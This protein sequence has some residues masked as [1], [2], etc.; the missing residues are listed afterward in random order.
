M[1]FYEEIVELYLTAVEGCAVIPQVPILESTTG[2]P[3]EAYPD[4]L[5]IDFSK[6]EISIVEVTKAGTRDVVKRFSAKLKDQYR[7]N[8]EQYIK[9]KTLNNQLSFTTHWR[10]FV[11]R[12]H[13]KLLEAST[14]YREY[15][16][17]GGKAEVIALED[18]LDRIRDFTLRGVR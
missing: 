13:V 4:F 8:V 3:W 1:D 16:E 7:N 15:L 5:A 12:D 9:K 18:I 6:R 2:E 11:R 10:F 17:A 14:N